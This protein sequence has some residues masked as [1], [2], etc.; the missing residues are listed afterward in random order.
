[1]KDNGKICW[2]SFFATLDR[3]YARINKYYVFVSPLNLELSSLLFKNYGYTY[4]RLILLFA[5]TLSIVNR[6]V[7]TLG[8]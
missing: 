6:C 8:P 5:F 2:F 3:Q 7:G 4:K 1:M